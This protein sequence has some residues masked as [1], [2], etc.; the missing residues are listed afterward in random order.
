[1]GPGLETAIVGS[2]ITTEQHATRTLARYSPTFG[3]G[4]FSEVRRH[5]V[6]RSSLMAVIGGIIRVLEKGRSDG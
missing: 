1:M 3:E 5:G 2:S 4:V 6:L